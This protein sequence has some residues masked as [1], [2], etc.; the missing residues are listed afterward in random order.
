MWNFVEIFDYP[1]LCYHVKYCIE[2]FAKIFLR[3]SWMNERSSLKCSWNRPYNDVFGC[4]F[5][6]LLIH[7]IPTTNRPSFIVFAQV[8]Y[9]FKGRTK[10]GIFDMYG[11][12]RKGSSTEQWMCTLSFLHLTL[13]T[14]TTNLYFP[15]S[16]ILQI[17][18]L[19]CVW[20]LPPQIY[21]S[22]YRHT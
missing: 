22:I 14:N 5:R 10:M 8:G 11:E 16:I 13:F 15:F 9:I 1:K 19:F 20:Y 18:L 12:K 3:Y 7:M 21:R 4:S 6:H 2:S 17:L